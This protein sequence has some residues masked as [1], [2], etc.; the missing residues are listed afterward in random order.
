MQRPG[1][2]QKKIIG[3]K[4]HKN[5]LKAKSPNKRPWNIEHNIFLKANGKQANKQQA[6]EMR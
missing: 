5:W 4:W 1:K 2:E 6:R 3:M